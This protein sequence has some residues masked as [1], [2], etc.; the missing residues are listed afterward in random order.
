MSISIVITAA[1][2]EKIFSLDPNRAAVVFN[3]HIDN[4]FE[5]WIQEIVGGY[6]PHLILEFHMKYVPVTSEQKEV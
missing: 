1:D 5:E 2:Y 3:K 6:L 4:G